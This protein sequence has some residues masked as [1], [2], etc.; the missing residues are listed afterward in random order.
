MW[1]YPFV[2]ISINLKKLKWIFS[3]PSSKEASHMK[4]FLLS[5]WASFQDGTKAK[6]TVKNIYRNIGCCE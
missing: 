1:K 6:Q 4:K 3:K 2:K 5:Q